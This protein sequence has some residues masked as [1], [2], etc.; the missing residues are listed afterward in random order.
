MR[1]FAIA[2]YKFVHEHTKNELNKC[3]AIDRLTTHRIRE[4]FWILVQVLHKRRHVR[5]QYDPLAKNLFAMNS[6]TNKWNYE[7]NAHCEN[8]HYIRLHSNISSN[9]SNVWLPA[10]LP[11]CFTSFGTLYV[12]YIRIAITR[13]IPFHHHHHCR[14]A[15]ACAS[16]VTA[17]AFIQLLSTYARQS[18]TFL[19]LL[20]FHRIQCTLVLRTNI[21]AASSLPVLSLCRSSNMGLRMVHSNCHRSRDSKNYFH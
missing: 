1:Y 2:L 8:Y 14:G 6:T 20:H 9:P 12:A 4:E 17:I 11:A 19:F 18:E 10:C 21:T 3:N 7:L 13:F 15:G 16:A 5:L